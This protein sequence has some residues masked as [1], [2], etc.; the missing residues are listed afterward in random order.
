[1]RPLSPCLWSSWGFVEPGEWAVQAG[2][3]RVVGEQFAVFGSWSDD[4]RPGLGFAAPEQD[5][6]FGV[7]PEAAASALFV[8][9]FDSFHLT[10]STPSRV[11]AA[12]LWCL[13]GYRCLSWL[14]VT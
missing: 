14:P 11:V 6:T 1:M 10:F 9:V 8:E 2:D 12:A 3:A 4:Y 5:V 7:E 13:R